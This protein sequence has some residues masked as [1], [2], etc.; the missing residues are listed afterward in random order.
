LWRAAIPIIPSP[1]DLGFNNPRAVRGSPQYRVSP[2]GNALQG[3]GQDIARLGATAA[4]AQEQ[5]KAE[6][7]KQ[8]AFGVQSRY[9]QFEDQW[10]KAFVDRARD[11]PAGAASFNDTLQSDYT[12]SAKEFMGTVPLPLKVE[13]DQKLFGIESRLTDAGQRFQN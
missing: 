8:Q 5:N 3:F 12:T 6:L 11:A 10:S 1:D 13:Y 2:V 9:L 7:D 4:Q